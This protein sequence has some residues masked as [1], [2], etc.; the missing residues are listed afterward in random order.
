M[1]YLQNRSKGLDGGEIALLIG[2]VLILVVALFLLNAAILQLAWNHGVV[3]AFGTHAISFPTSFWLVGGLATV[4]GV[5][6]GA[7]SASFNKDD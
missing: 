7:S 4:G 1:N 3:H 6:R 5:L 2:V